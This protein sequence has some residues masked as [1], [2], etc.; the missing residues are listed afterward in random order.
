MLVRKENKIIRKES[1][2]SVKD[3]AED[4]AFSLRDLGD[5]AFSFHNKDH[6]KYIINCNGRELEVDIRK[7]G[8]SGRSIEVWNIVIYENFEDGDYEEL[9]RAESRIV[10]TGDYDEDISQVCS[11]A[12]SLVRD[13]IR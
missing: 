11:D 8:L 1:M 9:D 5:V 6:F 10:L 4:M 7:S 13:I 12:V 3:I 2:K